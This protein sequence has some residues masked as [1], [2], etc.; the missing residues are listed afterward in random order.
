MYNYYLCIYGKIH[1]LNNSVKNVLKAYSRFFSRLNH[2]KV[3]NIYN[4]IK[5]L[6]IDF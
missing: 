3:I 4:I 1:I 2:N 6:I 5:I